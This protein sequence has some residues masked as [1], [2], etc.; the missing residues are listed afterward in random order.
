MGL[1]NHEIF[2]LDCSKLPLLIVK[3]GTKTGYHRV[4]PFYPEWFDAWNLADVQVPSCT[5]KNNSA[6]GNRVTHA[7]KRYELPF[8]PYDLRHAWA[9]RTIAFKVPTTLA[10]RMMGHSVDVHEKIYQQWI[11]ED[12]EAQVIQRLMEGDR[13]LAPGSVSELC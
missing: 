3:D 12:F 11:T 10:A 9:V 13:P 6:L 1:R 2:H 7:L 8:Q 4:H 5:G